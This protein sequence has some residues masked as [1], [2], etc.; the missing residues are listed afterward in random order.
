[1][2]CRLLTDLNFLKWPFQN[3]KSMDFCLVIFLCQKSVNE[4]LILLKVPG[5]FR[6]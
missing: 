3:R 4:F 6:I 2:V 5:Q 1:M